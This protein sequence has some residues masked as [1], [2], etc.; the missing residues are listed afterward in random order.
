MAGTL[1]PC[2]DPTLAAFSC[3]C[4]L[5]LLISENYARH[6]AAASALSHRVTFPGLS[7]FEPKQLGKI[8]AVTKQS[9][10]GAT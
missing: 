9:G 4:N 10:A 5:A 3:S 6:R 1:E 8:L 7:G 2:T